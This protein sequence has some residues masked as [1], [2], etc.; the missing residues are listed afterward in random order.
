[1]L[2]QERRRGEVFELGAAVRSVWQP[3]GALK[4]G[5]TAPP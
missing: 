2:A 1:M 4:E 3:R 5:G